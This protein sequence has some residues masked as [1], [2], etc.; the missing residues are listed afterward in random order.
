MSRLGII[1]VRKRH[2][3]HQMWIYWLHRAH[4]VAL[5]DMMVNHSVS[6]RFSK[7]SMWCESL[8]NPLRMRSRLG[9]IQDDVRKW[10]REQ[11]GFQT[12]TKSP[13]RL[14]WRHFGREIVANSISVDWEGPSTDCR[15]FDG[16]DHQSIGMCM[17][18]VTTTR[19]VSETQTNWLSYVGADLRKALYVSAATFNCSLSRERSQRRPTRASVMWPEECR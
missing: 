3:R 7:W 18:E 17:V 8:L 5:V 15:Q 16:K 10:D 12:L 2:Q 9:S 11:K 14:S 13:Q 1:Q 6:P 4:S 19:Y